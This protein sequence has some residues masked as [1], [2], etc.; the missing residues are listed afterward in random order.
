MFSGGLECTIS[1]PFL[2]EPR[3]DGRNNG[4]E[5]NETDRLKVGGMKR[6]VFWRR[7]YRTRLS[8][9]IP[10]LL[11]IPVVAGTIYYFTHD[12]RTTVYSSKAAAAEAAD[13]AGRWSLGVIGAWLAISVTCAVVGAVLGPKCR[14]CKQPLWNAGASAVGA[15][16]NCPRCGERVLEDKTPGEDDT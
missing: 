8:V 1:L 12:L 3:Y 10:S 5:R 7:V 14:A 6:Q 15:S 11:T 9:W 16:G 4:T 2:G 13:L